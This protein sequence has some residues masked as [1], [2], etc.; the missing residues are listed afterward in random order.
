MKNK[1]DTSPP[2]A[3]R[4]RYTDGDANNDN[5][6]EYTPSLPRRSDV[7]NQLLNRPLLSTRPVIIQINIGPQHNAFATQIAWFVEF[8]K[9]SFFKYCVWCR[10][11][12]RSICEA[13]H[14]RWN[15]RTSIHHRYVLA[16]SDWVSW[17]AA[18]SKT[19]S[20]PVTKWLCGI[21][22]RP[23]AANSKMQ[24]L[25]RLRRHVTSSIALI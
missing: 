23:S 3:K 19:W 22:R 1:H 8:N 5:D 18:S 10:S 9:L 6:H 21:A 12:Q 13:Y 2:A 7:V 15:R 25:L 16:S 11:R 17:A 20:I 4:N 24:A 14:K